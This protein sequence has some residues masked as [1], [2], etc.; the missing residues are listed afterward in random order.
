MPGTIAA[1]GVVVPE[2]LFGEAPPIATLNRTT[3]P[4]WLAVFAHVVAW[5]WFW[6]TEWKCCPSTLAVQTMS[7]RRSSER[8]PYHKGRTL[9]SS[10]TQPRL[11]DHGERNQG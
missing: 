5:T 9:F 4:A 3:Y 2:L 11:R 7:V 1:P 10:P 6:Q 8:V